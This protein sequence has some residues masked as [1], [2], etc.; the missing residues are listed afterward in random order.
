[1][2]VGTI[3]H[4]CPYC[5]RNCSCTNTWFWGDGTGVYYS[6]VTF[7]ALHPEPTSGVERFVKAAESLAARRARLSREAVA[8]WRRSARAVRVSP[9]PSVSPEPRRARAVAL[10]EAWRCNP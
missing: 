8:R 4:A 3:R 2:I 5:G 1:V 6:P 9:P 10:S 7:I